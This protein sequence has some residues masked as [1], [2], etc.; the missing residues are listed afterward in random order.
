MKT[1]MW[2]RPQQTINPFSYWLQ[3]GKSFVPSIKAP[4]NFVPAKKKAPVVVSSQAPMQSN[5]QPQ[6]QQS[7]APFNSKI[8]GTSPTFGATN[9]NTNPNIGGVTSSQ[10][11]TQQKIIDSQPKTPVKLP[12]T[13]ATKMSNEEIKKRLSTMGG[14]IVLRGKG[15]EEIRK[16]YPEFSHIDDETFKKIG[17][18]I[19]LR[20]KGV[21]D[22]LKSYPQLI[23]GAN[24]EKN[25]NG[26]NSDKNK[27]L[28]SIDAG[29]VKSA[30]GLPAFSMNMM[31]K[32]FGAVDK[33][34]V[35]PIS[36][37]IWADEE[38]INKNTKIAQDS[39]NDIIEWTKNLDLTTNPNANRDSI[40]YKGAKLWGD[41]TQ[42]MLL[43]WAKI[44]KGLTPLKTGL[45]FLKQGAVE[46]AKYKAVADSEL[47]SIKELALWAGT[48]L[49]LWAVGNGIKSLFKIATTPEAKQAIIWKITQI[50]DPTKL[51]K[52]GKALEKLDIPENPTY[53]TLLDATNKSKNKLMS[54][55]DDALTKSDKVFTPENTSKVISSA[56]TGKT[57]T[58]NYVEDA[59]S[60]LKE[61]YENQ[62]LDDMYLKVDDLEE[63]YRTKGLS[64]PQLNNLAK[65]YWAENKAFN[66]LW[67]K[68]SSKV[69]LGHENVRKGIKSLVREWMDES[70]TA[71]DKSYSDMELLSQAFG[72]MIKKVNSTA[73]RTVKPTIMKQAGDVI[74]KGLDIAT[75]W[76]AGGV[77][78]WLT[79]SNVGNKTLNNLWVQ[80]NLKGNI[81]KLLRKK[82]PLNLPNLSPARI[83]I[84]DIISKDKKKD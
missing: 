20:G 13:G 18:D 10:I 6:A 40:A 41:L 53:E 74:G 78:Q 29:L 84:V 79:K 54:E 76:T 9:I 47:P 59:F 80:E 22:I 35:D 15:L 12:E 17:G 81:N 34:V 82:P 63:A 70:V 43:P 57:R 42:S 49:L 31:D 65:I 11:G 28:S 27:T 21:D 5:S 83:P 4:I 58:R 77:L 48:N 64:H 67:D 39:R 46:T 68:L 66:R 37:K 73:N 52:A 3:A 19:A 45:W 56:E 51:E 50:T 7:Q 33:Y 16:S 38:T 32:V 69:A 61:L 72:D 1:L 8:G 60:Y 24:T 62:G 2:E 30:T 25:N 14:D 26:N 75:F 55:L 23:D 71:L 36:R 44:Q